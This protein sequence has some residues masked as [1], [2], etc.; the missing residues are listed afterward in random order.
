MSF[1]QLN[2]GLIEMKSHAIVT[3]DEN[4]YNISRVRD[5]CLDPN[6]LAVHLIVTEGFH[7]PTKFKLKIQRITKVNTYYLFWGP[8]QS[9]QQLLR[10]TQ[11]GYARLIRDSRVLLQRM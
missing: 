3:V 9:I 1:S 4:E 2:T 11:D 6:S 7:I 8:S 5:V 10:W